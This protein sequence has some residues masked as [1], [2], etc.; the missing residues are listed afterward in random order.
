MNNYSIGNCLLPVEGSLL[1]QTSPATGTAARPPRPGPYLAHRREEDLEEGTPTTTTA[2]R[3]TRAT[4][5]DS[6]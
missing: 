6:L 4:I 3:A 1:G 5:H 2:R